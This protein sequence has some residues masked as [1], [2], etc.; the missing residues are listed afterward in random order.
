M[1]S[2]FHLLI[3]L[4]ILQNVVVETNQKQKITKQKNVIESD[5]S[6]ASISPLLRQSVI[7]LID[8]SNILLGS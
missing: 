6:K 3:P 4:A 2:M 8:P 1:L 5:Q 7:I